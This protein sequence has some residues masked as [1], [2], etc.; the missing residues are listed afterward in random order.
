MEDL[1]S[2]AMKLVFIGLVI[3]AGYSVL[4]GNSDDYETGVEVGRQMILEAVEGEPGYCDRR[5]GY[6]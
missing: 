1:G 2:A 6:D 5:K 4:G 3:W